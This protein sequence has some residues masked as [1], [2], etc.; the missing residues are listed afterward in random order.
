MPRPAHPPAGP[1]SHGGTD[2]PGVR[3]W[4]AA[5]LLGAIRRRGA[6]RIEDVRFR[7]NRR[8]IWSLTRGGRR[9]NLHVAFRDA[10]HE[11]VDDLAVIAREAA[12]RTTAARR[13]AV[14]VERW[15]PLRAAMARIRADRR[16]SANRP[17]PCCGTPDQRAYLQRLY[18]HLNVTR[19]EG[20]LPDSVPIRLS[21][22]MTRRLG[23][24]APDREAGA[25]RIREIALNVDLMLPANDAL[26][27]E[28][29]L[30]EM[31]H[32]LEYLLHGSVGHGPLWRAIAT[33][34]GCEPRAFRSTRFS[35]RPTGQPTV[36]RVPPDPSGSYPTDVRTGGH[37]PAVTPPA[38][39]APPWPP[40]LR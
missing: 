1:D 18:R 7:R 14:R 12:R 19:F 37:A 13:A 26:R 3:L 22:R 29:L 9:L 23:H 32:G 4:D 21:N 30:H 33:E 8:T 25:R 40:P 24:M 39:P 11:V 6:V 36:T 15:P 17:G 34:V 2:P 35:R 28:T 27:A 31:A 16:P 10:P 20:R 38:P 5:S